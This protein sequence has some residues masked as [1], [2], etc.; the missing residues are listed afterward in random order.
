M[1]TNAANPK[2]RAPARPK[3]PNPRSKKQW[4]ERGLLYSTLIGSLL[5]AGPM[6]IDQLRAIS[7]GINGS[8]RAA[9]AQNELWR[10]NI[11]CAA[12]PYA[13][14]NNPS[15]IKVDATICDSGDIF[16]RANTPDNT[17]FF[18]WVPLD[19][20][21]KRAE[22]S[23]GKGLLGARLAIGPAPEARSMVH[24][25]QGQAVIICQKFLDNRRLLRRVQTP[26]GCFDE[27]VD[28]FNGTVVSRTAV[29]CS[30]QC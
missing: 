22:A 28:T 4:I 5:T 3:R 15:N 23:G 7:Q 14:F 27:V 8:A 21:L 29:A 13:W 25:A 19:D 9:E 12:S 16:V 26:Q 17:Q 24:L 10:K 18:K 6:W 11:D 1:A 20:V 30:P 2:A